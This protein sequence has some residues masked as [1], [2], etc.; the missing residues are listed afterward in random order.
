MP[1]LLA[2]LAE[3]LLNIKM[4]H[5]SGKE[6]EDMCEAMEEWRR[7][8]LEE[9]INEGLIAG[10]VEGLEAGRAESLKQLIRKLHI[11]MQEAFD[12]LDIAEEDR[13]RYEQLLDVPV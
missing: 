8:L 9:G 3:G 5:S 4:T 1:A 11:S 6:T 7:Q 10:K 2:R 13:A 12:L